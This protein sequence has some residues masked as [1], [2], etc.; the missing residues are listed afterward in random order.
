LGG[1]AGLVGWR[2]AER[3]AGEADD[4][5]GGHGPGRRV[6]LGESAHGRS[7]LREQRPATRPLRSATRPRLRRWFARCAPS[8]KPRLTAHA[9]DA[10]RVRRGGRPDLARGQTLIRPAP[11]P[12]TRST[13]RSTRCRG[14]TGTGSRRRCRPRPGAGVD[15]EVVPGHQVAGTGVA[16]AAVERVVGVLE[17]VALDE[18]PAFIV[19][20][21]P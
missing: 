21:T 20:A 17:V 3:A 10:R 15:E 1:R 7:S 11:A 9:V 12:P 13:S 18:D 4:G 8:R 14:C 5:R 16:L 19:D 2:V 6:R